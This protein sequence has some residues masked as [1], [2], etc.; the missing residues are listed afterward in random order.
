MNIAAMLKSEISRLARKELRT[1]TE[2][3]KTASAKYRGEI[4]ALKRDVAELKRQLKVL[5]KRATGDR[6]EKTE[7]GHDQ[8]IRIRFSAKG[9]A[10]QRQRLG[11]SAENF[12]K[13]I[14]VSGQTIYLWE[15]EKTKPRNGQ[16]QSIATV[17]KMGKREAAAAL[18]ENG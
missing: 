3:L 17:R 5:S 16:L 12:G 14:G 8:P 10:A 7:V 2:A 4:A 11:L 18:G 15:A 6:P 1:E 13:L 9:L